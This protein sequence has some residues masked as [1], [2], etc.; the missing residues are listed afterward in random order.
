SQTVTLPWVPELKG[1]DV[2]GCENPQDPGV[3]RVVAGGAYRVRSTRPIS[4]YQLNPLTYKI[5][6]APA[7]CPGTSQTCPGSP[8]TDCNSY[9]NDASLLLPTNTLTRDYPTLAWP[10]T[11]N[12]ASFIAVTAVQDGTDVELLG[13][14]GAIA[15]GAGIDASGAGK[16]TLA[17]GD[18][19]EI[20]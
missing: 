4:A 6:P 9:S 8:L 18:V 13:A 17:R 10:A 19:L 1:P 3:T 14:T 15:A 20:I 12:R 5:D 7:G 2:D 11:S 16:V